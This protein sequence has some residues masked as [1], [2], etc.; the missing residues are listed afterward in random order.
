MV[1]L[2]ASLLPEKAASDLLSQL[3][4][5]KAAFVVVFEQEA[6]SKA[7]LAGMKKKYF[8]YFIVLSFLL[9]NN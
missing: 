5:V 7:T 6:T 2:I 4:L 9:M 8:K 1:K 3:P